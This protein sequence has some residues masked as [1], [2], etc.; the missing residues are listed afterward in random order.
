[1][2]RRGDTGG[3]V[4]IVVEPLEDGAESYDCGN[5][6]HRTKSGGY[7]VEKSYFYTGENLQDYPQLS[8]H[9]KIIRVTAP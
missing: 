2:V 7:P 6:G 9:G 4:A 5:A 1:M 3:H 8:A